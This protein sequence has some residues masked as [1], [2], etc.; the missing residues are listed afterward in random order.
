MTSNFF[1]FFL[2][3]ISVP[4]SWAEETIICQL[5][6]YNVSKNFCSIISTFKNPFSFANMYYTE[7][8]KIILL[9][10]FLM[11]LIFEFFVFPLSYVHM[12]TSHSLRKKTQ[13]MGNCTCLGI[14]RKFQ[15]NECYSLPNAVQYLFEKFYFF[16]PVKKKTVRKNNSGGRGGSIWNTLF[17]I[18]SFYNILFFK[19]KYSAGWEAVR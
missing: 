7:V 15:G 19:I 2:Q 5:W 3:L 13:S 9:K 6:D 8:T 18:E 16:F 11:Y 4:T 10:C 1:F 14:W 17:I 12:F